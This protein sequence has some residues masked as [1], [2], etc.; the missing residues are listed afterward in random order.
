MQKTKDN[1]KK[2]F[3]KNQSTPL[4]IL[5]DNTKETKISTKIWK[6]KKLRRE[7]FQHKKMT[8]Y[9]VNNSIFLNFSNKNNL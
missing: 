3:T 9:Q 1:L 2:I 5:Q 7:D 6:D 8:E 4:L